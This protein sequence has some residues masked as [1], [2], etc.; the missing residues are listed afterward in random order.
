MRWRTPQQLLLAALA[1]ALLAGTLGRGEPGIYN[2][3]AEGELTASDLASALGWYSI[4]VPDL[5]VDATAEIVSRIPFLPA[6]ATWV[7]A[8]RVPVVMDT[9]K[10]RKQL[11]WKPKHDTASTLRQT[12][13]SARPDLEAG[14]DDVD[15]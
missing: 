14:H 11:K 5:A 9:T 3:A 12:V 13:E 7:N 4:P 2:L 8:A 1:G 6:E 10:A 15:D